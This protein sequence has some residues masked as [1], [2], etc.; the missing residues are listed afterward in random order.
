MDNLSFFCSKL[1]RFPYMGGVSS[2]IELVQFQRFF[3]FSVSFFVFQSFQSCFVWTTFPF[4]VQ[5]YNY[6]HIWEMFPLFVNWCNFNAFFSQS[7]FQCDF[8]RQPVALSAKSVPLESFS[9]ARCLAMPIPVK[10]FPRG[11]VTITGKLVPLDFF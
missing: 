10:Y 8:S 6:S 1:Q 9:Q 7:F 5:S 2:F 11:S 4:F 3:V